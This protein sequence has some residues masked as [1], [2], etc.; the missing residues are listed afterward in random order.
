MSLGFDIKLEQKQN[1]AMTTEL[2]QAIKLLQLNSLDLSTYMQEQLRENPVLESAAAENPAKEEGEAFDKRDDWQDDRSFG[3]TDWTEQIERLI[4]AGKGDISYGQRESHSAD[5]GYNYENFAYGVE[6]LKEHLKMQLRMTALPEEDERMADY[7]VECIDDN[8][9]ISADIAEIGAL[10]GASPEHAEEVLKVIQT[11][12]PYGVGARNLQ[13]C[14]IIQL[15]NSGRCTN[16]LRELISHHMEDLAAN[17]ISRIAKEM[18]IPVKK[19]QEYCDTVRSLEPKPGR[20]FAGSDSPRY[21]IPDISLE[22]LG[23]QY[24]VNFNSASLPRL[25]ISS[26][27]QSMLS[28]AKNDKELSD[29]LKE[30]VDSAMWLIRSIEQ[31]NSTIV[32]VATAIVNHQK[33]FFD[34]GEDFLKPLTLR[35]IAEEVGVHESTVSRAVSGKYLQAGSGVYELKYFFN[36]AISAGG[37]DESVA[38]LAVRKKIKDL[39]AGENPASPLSDQAIAEM[40]GKSGIDISRRTIAKYRDEMHIPSSSKRKRY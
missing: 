7:I 3:E 13:E 10:F 37:S 16:G 21:V 38:S 36:S 33:D 24:A 39:I 1:L 22:K 26:F 2:V 25:Q 19:L 29:Y 40:L 27:Y 34:K 31:R 32:K 15:E 28:R 6:T 30:K 17:K 20:Q 12:E 18:D 14:L 35:Q 9:Y 23:D 8:G 11:F 5:E 4:D